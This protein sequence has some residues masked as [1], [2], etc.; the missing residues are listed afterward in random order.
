MLISKA[1]KHREKEPMKG[2]IGM[3]TKDKI[4]TLQMAEV[5]LNAAEA[6]LGSSEVEGMDFRA[7]N[8]QNTGCDEVTHS[9]YRRNFAHFALMWSI[10]LSDYK[11]FDLATLPKTRKVIEN[12]NEGVRVVAARRFAVDGWEV[13]LPYS[14]RSAGVL[15]SHNLDRPVEKIVSVLAFITAATLHERSEFALRTT[16]LLRHAVNKLQHEL[17]KGDHA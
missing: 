4:L 3:D 7:D 17:G 13:V 15:L 9:L 2:V 16:W 8:C 1:G 6:I 12:T 10:L 14:H 5:L 11:A